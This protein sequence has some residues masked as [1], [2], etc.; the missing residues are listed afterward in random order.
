MTY[1]KAAV[2]LDPLIHCA[3]P[4]IE[5]ILFRDPIHCIWVLNLLYHSRNS[6]AIVL[7]NTSSFIFGSLYY[8][9][10]ILFL[11]KFSEIY[12][13]SN[14]HLNICVITSDLSSHS[15]LFIFSLTYQF[16]DK[17][18]IHTFALNVINI[19]TYTS[20]MYF[21]NKSYS[22]REVWHWPPAFQA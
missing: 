11:I 20:T 22:Q 10:L 5:P 17:I 1:A 3:G 13:L 9:H 14:V 4:R 19:H 6:K 15:Q 18:S 16:V 7:S 21:P 8:K 2:M 12:I